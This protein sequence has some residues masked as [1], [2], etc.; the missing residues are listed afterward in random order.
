MGESNFISARRDS[1]R[2]GICLDLFTFLLI[3]LC[4]HLINYFF[5]PLRR[6]EAIAWENFVPAVQKT[7]LALPG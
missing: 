6:T 4:K 3:F 7:D 1:F 5:I 2:P